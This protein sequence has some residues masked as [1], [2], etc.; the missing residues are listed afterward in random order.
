MTD[1]PEHT[2]LLII[3]GGVGGYA[4]AFRAIDLGIDVTLVSEEPKLGGVCLLRGCIPSKA[5][6]EIAELLITTREASERGIEFDSPNIDL[7][8]LRDWKNGVVEQLVDGLTGLAKKRGLRVLHGRATF[9]SSGSVQL[10][11][12]DEDHTIR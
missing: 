7:S 1:V 3:G 9:E 8:R 5:M 6:L 10:T 2:D 4:A 12:D 11:L